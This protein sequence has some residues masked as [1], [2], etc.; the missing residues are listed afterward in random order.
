MYV[1]TVGLE[2]F[3]VS[4]TAGSLEP[5]DSFGVDGVLLAA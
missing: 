2:G 5:V 1:R 3:V 4:L